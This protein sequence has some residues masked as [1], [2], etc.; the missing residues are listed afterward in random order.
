MRLPDEF[1]S[2]HRWLLGDDYNKFMQYFEKP[3]QRQSIRVNTLKSTVRQVR[4][5]LS[6]KNIEYGPVP[7]CPDGLWVSEPNMDSLEHQL[8]FY[9]IQAASSMISPQILGAGEKVLDM[10]AAPGG[11]T[12]HL[13]QLMG[14]T[15][16]IVAN[17]KTPARIKALVYNI[18]RMGVSNAFVTRYDAIGFEK[19]ETGFDRVLLD[20]PCSG[21]G[22]LRQSR[23]ILS[24]W[25]IDWVERLAALQKK[26]ILSAFDCIAPGGKMVYT[27][28]TTT[29]EENE[30]V[31]EHLLK[32][33]PSAKLSKVKLDGI[34]L[35]RSM[36]D[37]VR[38]CARV[39]PQDNQSDPHFIAEVTK[40]E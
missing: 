6:E 34:T 8:G 4:R 39:F 13:A 11:K 25:S 19:L 9:Y 2:Y 1:E 20:A 17:E 37:D 7:W 14:G 28:C 3:P 27:T 30:Q 36:S 18:Q 22:T 40:N 35:R 23:E 33:R 31:V 15:G 26:M 21:V 32:M 24:R 29:V 12:T 38:E 5:I 10:C 16:T